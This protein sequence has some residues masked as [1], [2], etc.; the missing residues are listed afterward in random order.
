MKIERTDDFKAMMYALKDIYKEY[1]SIAIYKLLVELE[2][3]DIAYN[4]FIK[5]T[6]KE[7][8]RNTITKQDKHFLTF[9]LVK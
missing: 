8:S 7:L 6:I 9:M 1:G 3:D 4:D 2:S 5:T